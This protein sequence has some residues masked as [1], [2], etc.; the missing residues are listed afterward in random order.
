MSFSVLE[1]IFEI[2][3]PALFVIFFCVFAFKVGFSEE[4]DFDYMKGE[5][6]RKTSVKEK[7][8]IEG[9]I[10]KKP[11]MSEAEKKETYQKKKE[12]KGDFDSYYGQSAYGSEDLQDPEAN[13]FRLDSDKDE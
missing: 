3:F 8:L 10:D 12:E 7:E 11:R 1:D 9:L 4:S 2:G 13:K 5:Q 6:Q